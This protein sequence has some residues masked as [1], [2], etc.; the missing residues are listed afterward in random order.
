[1]LV[2]DDPYAAAA[3][4]LPQQTHRA[5]ISAFTLAQRMALFLQ[6]S[7]QKNWVAKYWRL[8]WIAKTGAMR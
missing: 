1:M 2:S 4:R 3:G 7:F 8:T 5:D 6:K